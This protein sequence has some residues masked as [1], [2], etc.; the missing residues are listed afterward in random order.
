MSD[1]KAKKAMKLALENGGNISKAM[2]EA[3][4]SNAMA[5]NP[6]KLKKSKQWNELLEEYLP[7][8]LLAQ[9]HKELLT[10]N[11]KV[12]HYVK[13]DLESEYEELDSQAISKGL[14]MAYKLKGTYAAERKEISGNINIASL[15]NSEE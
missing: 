10:V 6:Q 11:K 8:K 3:G 4:Y 14:D 12:R 7:N 5:K 15:L 2:R 13:G 1:L 9:K